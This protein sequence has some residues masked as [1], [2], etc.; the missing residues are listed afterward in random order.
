MAKYSTIVVIVYATV[1]IFALIIAS[2]YCAIEV[3]K[4]RT[5]QNIHQLAILSEKTV[6]TTANYQ[7][8]HVQPEESKPK[9]KTAPEI[10]QQRE[11]EH[12]YPATT[13]NASAIKMWI[14]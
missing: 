13:G 7:T 1:Y 6:K 5:Q 10:I 4:K 9:A 11:F 12:D 14:K 2:I 3:Q 8:K